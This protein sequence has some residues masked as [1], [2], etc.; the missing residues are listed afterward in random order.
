MGKM[1]STSKVLIRLFFCHRMPER[2][3]FFK[4]KQFPICARC[5]GIL[6]GI[7]LGFIYV[8]FFG[9]IPFLLIPLFLLPIAFDGGGQLLNKWISNNRRRLI[10]GVL[11][12]L[13]VDF[14][15]YKIGALGFKY[16]REAA[17]FFFS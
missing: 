16:G 2:S 3:F 15:F 4:G 12:G 14:L 10:T 17:R 8:L 6:V 13:A 7:I 5:T 11:A 1:D 9:N